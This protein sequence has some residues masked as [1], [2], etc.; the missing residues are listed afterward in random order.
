MK[1]VVNAFG[2]TL[3][4]LEGLAPSTVTAQQFNSDSWLSK[5]HGVA[6]I[7]VT[8]GQRNSMIMTTFS[9]LPR[10]EFTV[11]DYLYNPD[12]DTHTNDGYST[13]LYAKYMFYENKAKTG[14]AAVKFGTGME[15]GYLD[16]QN[17]LKDAFKTYW[18][19]APVTLSFLNDRLSWDIM[20]G[21]SLTLP[22]AGDDTTTWAFTYTTRL[23]WYPAGPHWSIVGEVVGAAG[24][25]AAKPEYRIGYRWEPNKYVVIAATYDDEF[26]GDNGAGGEIGMML[27][28]PPFFCIGNCQN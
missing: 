6:T 16:S 14:G 24:P 11:S 9:L 10:W 8:Y 3:V 27:F 22:S 12:R 18:T 17:R 26:H 13:S 25:R 21:V 15:P 23:A 1:A 20:P 4:V 5:P 2:V 19:N 7:I 28:T